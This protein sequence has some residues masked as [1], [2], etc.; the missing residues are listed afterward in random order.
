MAEWY[1]FLP[2][3]RVSVADIVERSHHAEASGFT[4]VAFIDHLKAPGLPDENIWEAISVATWVAA[5]TERL[6]IGHLV[7]RRVS[8][9]GGAGR[10]G[11]HVVR[12]LGRQIRT[13]PRLR[14]LARRVH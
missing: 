9:S 14:L 13:R 2:Q 5:K 8:P 12:S 6:R 10:T 11:R 7:C 1:L 3:V 4:G